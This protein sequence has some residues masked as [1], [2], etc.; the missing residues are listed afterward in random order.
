MV[1]HLVILKKAYLDAI[2]AG[3]K[4]IE[5]RFSKSQQYFSGRVSAGDKLFLK[6]SSG[7]VCATA[8]VKA[9]RNF[10]NLTPE[11]IIEI[12]QQYNQHILGSDEYWQSKSDSRGGF[13][14]WLE[15]VKLIS[16]M[17]INKK[18]WRA[19]VVLT[20]KNNFGLL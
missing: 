19:W 15:D 11:Q 9:V 17:R 16:P 6:E 3:R 14:V 7:P 5:S 10:E 2:L 20:E 18:D 13:L 1:N 4:K 8:T 12:K